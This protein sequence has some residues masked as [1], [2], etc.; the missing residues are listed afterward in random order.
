MKTYNI[1]CKYSKLKGIAREDKNRKCVLK[2]CKGTQYIV[3]WEDGTTSV[4]CY[5]RCRWIEED[6]YEFVD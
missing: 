6:T 1:I 3:D 4:I 5:N 2:L